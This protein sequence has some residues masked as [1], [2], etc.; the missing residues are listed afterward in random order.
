VNIFISYNR[1]NSAFVSSVTEKIKGEI[2]ILKELFFDQD[3]LEGGQVWTEA[4]QQALSNSDA[5]IVFIGEQGIGNWQNKEVLTAV[6]K[7]VDSKGTFKLIPVIIPHRDRAQVQKN[8]PWFL[9]DIQW[10]EFFN[11]NDPD[12]FQK[13]MVRLNEG[14]VLLKIDPGSIPY[15]G[16]DFFEVEDAPFFFGRTFDVNWIFYKKLTLDLKTSSRFLAIIGDS[17][18]GKSSFA[19]AGI[20]ATLKADRFSGSKDWKLVT[21]SPE[22]SPLLKLS[23]AFQSA[24]II[25][26]AKKLEDDAKTDS[27]SLRRALET[28]AKKVVLLIDQFEEVVTQCKD[29]GQREAFL[30]N[31]VE[32][33]KSQHLVCIVTMRSD[34]YAAFAP[35]REFAELLETNNYTITNLDFNT[36]GEEWAPYLRD[37]IEKPA[38]LLGVHFDPLLTKQV[39]EDCKSINGVLPALQLALV[40]L[41]KKGKDK[42]KIESVDYDSLAHGKGIAGI[43]EAHANNVWKSLTKDETDKNLTNIIKALFIRLVEITGN[44]EDVRKTV[45]KSD[46]V[47]DLGAQFDPNDVEKILNIL[48]GPDVRLLRVKQNKLFGNSLWVEVIHE[49]L[50]RQWEKLRGWLNERREAIT[51]KDKLEEYIDDDNKLLTGKRLNAAEQWR[52]TNKDLATAKIN[53][54]ITLSRG[55]V[56]KRKYVLLISL[57]TLIMVTIAGW[58]YYP[59]YECRNCY[60]VKNLVTGNNNVEDVHSI[61][62]TGT[63]DIKYM[64]CL[65]YLDTLTIQ[66]KEDG[67][68]LSDENINELPVGLKQLTIEGFVLGDTLLRLDKLSKLQTLNISSLKGL[69][70]LGVDNL[71]SL[72]EINLSA[73][74]NYKDLEGIETVKNLRVLRLSRLDGLHNLSAI[75]NQK[76]L[77]SLTLSKLQLTELTELA[78]ISTLE[79]LT[80]GDLNIQGLSGVEKL[81]GL[82]YL[83]LSGLPK[84]SSLQGINNL[85]SLKSLSLDLHIDNIGAIQ[86]LTQLQSLYLVDLRI[87][88]LAD[89]RNLTNVQVLSISGLTI[90]NL[91]GIEYLKN[92]QQLHLARLSIQSLDEIKDLP[93]LSMLELSNLDIT[94][95]DGLANLHLKE[96][97]LSELNNVTNYEEIK[98]IKSLE[99]LYLSSLK[100][101]VIDNLA[102]LD[103]LKSLSII[104]LPDTTLAGLTNLKN[105]QSLNLSLIGIK[106]LTTISSLKNLAS[107]SLSYL[108][109]FTLAGIENLQNLAFLDLSNLPNLDLTGI[110]NLKNIRQLH[111]YNIGQATNES[112]NIPLL[113]HQTMMDTL[114]IEGLKLDNLDFIDENIKVKMVLFDNNIQLPDRDIAFAKKARQMKKTKFLDLSV[115]G[116]PFSAIQSNKL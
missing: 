45:N 14:E 15:K 42:Q 6:N 26:D 71:D 40:E 11:E 89:L 85:K 43:I 61:T 79:N 5:C 105:L 47:N 54:F 83:Q 25:P 114:L 56:N 112:V 98:K 24:G 31:I 36:A 72:F 110:K 66:A 49:A 58:L 93:A 63:S 102:S 34:F 87:A 99:T 48:S 115:W 113:T 77:R 68:Y 37:I 7:Y 22:D 33:L 50:I 2:I 82:Q 8:I 116:D 38:R 41:W 78:S 73:I 101:P 90:T 13:L 4:I 27:A 51:F 10:I 97:R 59:V 70:K 55:A 3:N 65:K 107:L 67:D 88:G 104:E 62:L 81:N 1:Q 35:F 74:D 28:Y 80:L 108:S 32:A 17:G 86:N 39:I 106:D 109:K 9:S 16:L 23:S 92:L 52:S 76:T 100:A 46:L 30:K 111:L 20:L 60:L 94:K 69:R 91:K 103:N 75:K 44:K 29:N 21:C 96:L 64:R 53:N 95:L 12:A 57:C 18:S 19:R 84:L